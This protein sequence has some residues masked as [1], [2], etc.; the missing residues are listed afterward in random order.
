MIKFIRNGR[1]AVYRSNEYLIFNGKLDN[2]YSVLLLSHNRDDLKKGFSL[3]YDEEYM[4]RRHFF[5]C[6]KEVPKSEITEAYEIRSHA[7]Y[8]GVEASIIGCLK[9][10]W[11][12]LRTC[13]LDGENKNEFLIKVNIAG[14]KFITRE[15]GGTDV[16]GLD[17]SLDD[18]DL[19][20]EEIRKEL[21]INKL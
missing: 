19:R 3:S 17:V 5:T 1:Y 12:G 9:E 18:P 20:I 7:V 10:N 4:L 11:I 8:K 21:D 13:C 2:R 14:F 16:Y 15:Q 6:E